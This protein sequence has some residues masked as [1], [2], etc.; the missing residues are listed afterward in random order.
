MEIIL[1]EVQ[2]PAQRKQFVDLVFRLYKGNKYWVPP[3]KSDEIHSLDPKFN[4]AFRFCK[5]KFW[6]A[7]RDNVVVGRIGAIINESYIKKTGEKIG[8]FSRAEFI[9]DIEVSKALFTTAEKW[10]KEQGMVSLQGPLGFTNLDTQGMLIEGFDHLPSVASV[11]HLPY[12]QEHLDKLGYEKE[13]DWVEFRLTMEGVPEK[14]E[15]LADMIRRRYNLKIIRFTTNKELKP[16]A[17]RVFKLLN[18]AF[19]ELFSVTAFDEEM[20]QYYIDKYFKL[21]NPKFVTLVENKE[22]E[23]AGFLIGV[24]SLSEAMQ[25]AN[26][27]VFPF[28]F[29]HLM[30]AMKHPKVVDLFLTGV[31]PKMQGMGITA[32]LINEIH[33]AIHEHHVEFAETTGILETNLK[34]IQHWK[35]YTHIQHKRRRCYKKL[36]PTP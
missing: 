35:N 17:E 18:M 13:I 14:A 24:P 31:D 28:G 19:E 10:L 25:K 20:T 2:T 23:L 7:L 33:K 9:D 16:H 3:I 32:L 21:L 34:A 15:K 27:H 22:G 36:L 11:Y 1:Q 5:A 29:I 12:Y 30:K 6:I 26:G 4:P 8:R